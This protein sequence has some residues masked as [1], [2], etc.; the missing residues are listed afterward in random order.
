MEAAS[1]AFLRMKKVLII[2][3]YWPPSG[4]AG[5]QR[6]LK[7]VKY[8]RNFG[9][10]PIVY[11]PSNPEIPVTDESLIKDIPN[12]IAI[13]QQP[14][15]EPYSWYKRW[16]GVKPSE[17]I[18]T[19]FLSESEKP[20]KSESVGVWIRGN[21]FIPD[22]RCFWIQPS[23]KFLSN[24]I[25]ENPVD[26][27]ISTGPPHSMHLIAKGVKEKCNI[28]W[29]ADFRDPWTNIDFYD[30]LMLTKWAD[31]KH[32][33]LETEVL[34]SAD[35]VTTVTS[36]DQKDFLEKGAKACEWIPNGYDD[37]FP[38]GISPLPL[39]ELV[40]VGSIPK[41]RNHD[42][43]WEA[44]HLATLENVHLKKDLSIR[45]VGKVDHSVKKSIHQF[46][47]TD[48]CK[49]QHYLPHEE[50]IETQQKSQILLLLVNNSGNAKSILTGKFFEYLAAKR[51]ILAIGPVD[52]EMNAILQSTKAGHCFDFGD[53]EGI[54]NQLLD[55]HKEFLNQGQINIENNDTS[56]FSR[57]SLTGKMSQL[58]LKICNQ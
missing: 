3:Y 20:K 33:R 4:G 38:L 50:A 35:M 57:K 58:I 46:E 2:T 36:F 6:W 42:N 28:P 29:L 22:A 1:I 49:F 8:F 16:V 26:A 19:G 40:H 51:P 7:F 11:T 31:R 41:S 24:Y 34:Q 12:D 18:N 17:K 43:L 10:E 14:I 27:I 48:Y 53:V 44:I 52:G 13:L 25:K 23:T 55:W 47:L 54:K 32:H 45:L 15:W 39:F 5:V 37:E 9:I 21:F 30:Q 56:V